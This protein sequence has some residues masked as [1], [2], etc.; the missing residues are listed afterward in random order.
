MPPLRSLAGFRETEKRQK[1]LMEKFERHHLS[2]IEQ[3]LDLPGESLEFTW[4]IGGADDETYQG[5][6]SKCR[7]RLGTKL[8]PISVLACAWS[9]SSV[10]VQERSL[11]RGTVP[12]IRPALLEI[13]PPRPDAV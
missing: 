8:A 9:R 11:L 13:L 6:R 5:K 7:R 10:I 12:F 1:A 4:D 3:L 2:S